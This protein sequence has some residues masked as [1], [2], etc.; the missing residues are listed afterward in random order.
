[1]LHLV[2]ALA[3]AEAAPRLTLVTRGACE[4]GD[5]ESETLSPA[6]APLWGLARSLAAELPELSCRCIDLDPREDRELAAAALALELAAA[7]DEDQVARRGGGRFVA[8][9]VRAVR[10]TVGREPEEVRLDTAEKGELANLALVPAPRR[11]PGPGEVEI[12]IEAS[13]L[14]FR[15]VLN[16]LGLYPGDAGAFGAECAGRVTAV[17]EGVGLAVGQ[18]VVSGFASGSFARHVVARADLVLPRPANL[19][20]EEAVTM[21]I[22]FLT[23]LYGLAELAQAQAGEWVLIHAAAGGVGLAALQVARRA[24]C[25]VIATAGSAEKRSYLAALGVEHV[26]SSRSL[27]FAEQ[28]MAVTGGRGVNVVLNSLSGEFIPRSLAVLAAGGRFVE[29]GI[30]SKIWPEAEV[31]GLRPDVAYFPFDLSRMARE[32]PALVRRLFVDF[33]AAVERG[34]YTPLPRRVFP[35]EEAAAAF[36]T[37]AQARH[38]GK[39]VVRNRPAETAEVAIRPD[40]TYLITGGLGALGLEV[41]RYFVE[42]GARHLALLGRSA[43]GPQA[44]I[45]LADLAARGA[46]VRTLRCDVADRAA[47]AAALAEVTEVAAAGPPLAGVVHA[48]GRLDDGV[49]GQMDWLRFA[50]VLAPKVAGA[51]NLHLATRD[52]PLDFFVL[53]S[54]AASLLGSAGQANYAAA[55]AFLDALAGWRRRQGLPATAIQWG[56]WSGGGMAAVAVEQGRLEGFGLRPLAP[57]QGIAIFAELLRDAPARVGVLPIDWARFAAGPRGQSPLTR[58]LTGQATSRGGVEAAPGPGGS[59]VLARLA[60]LAPD[61][62][63][64]ELAGYV[65]QQIARVLSLPAARRIDPEQPLKS[66]GLDSL[67]AVELRNALSRALGVPL[68]ATLVFDYPTLDKLVLFLLEKTALAPAPGAADDFGDELALLAELEQL[69]EEQAETLLAQRQARGY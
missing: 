49:L 42:R 28:V 62:R 33:L 38:I 51:W 31:A 39:I 40:A 54:S 30:G 13:A 24:G 57:E 56:T 36:R 7:D 61:D 45:V 55:N 44:A 41:A 16:A 21:P 9:L 35:L 59:E 2:Q 19:T 46:E 34:E 60:A 64:R 50:G 22:T 1:V 12:R 20:P 27:E 43:P 23:A 3:A 53:F 67:M 18:E 4:V 66:L 15:D 48:A 14:N 25:K 65:A 52:L 11:A 68:P 58:E 63:P 10:P 5:E 26:F 32:E 37:M 69:S 17:G 8:R 47:V 29:I 6:Q